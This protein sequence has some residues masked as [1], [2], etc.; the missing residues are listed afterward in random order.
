M[1]DIRKLIDILN[2]TTV[3][4]AIATGPAAPIGEVHKRVEEEQ[5]NETGLPEVIEY[6]NWENSALVTEKKT[7]SMR[8]RSKRVVK[9][10]YGVDNTSAEGGEASESQESE[11][12]KGIKESLDTVAENTGA[13][14]YAPKSQGGTRKE[15]LAKFKKTRNP[16][17]AEAARRAGATQRELQDVREDQVN[18]EDL[19]VNPAAIKKAM[20]IIAKDKVRTDHEVE[21]ARSDLFQAAK[22]AQQIHAMIKDRSE[23]DGL[24]GWVQEKIVK[25]ADYLNTVREYLEG[26]RVEQGVAEG[27]NINE[28]YIKSTKD[29]VNVLANLRQIAKH[30]EIGSPY[31]GNLANQ[32]ANDVWDVYSWLEN[33]ADV[34]NPQLKAILN[35]VFELRK[36]AKALE[37]GGNSGQNRQFANQIV[38]TLYPLMQWIQ[39]NVSDQQSVAEGKCPECGGPAFSEEAIA[40]AKDACYH[41]VKSRYKVWPSAYASGALSKCRKVGASNWGNKSK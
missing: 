19:I 10:V 20:G 38:N 7:K 41:K 14:D 13:T 30:I 24:E 40:E 5:T 21:M 11:K 39:M 22:N 34:Y 36:Q 31:N 6:G 35:N 1:S 16:K 9:S 28:A 29:A 8:P 2:E 15:L 27:Q 17:D 23:D 32:Y 4:G 18:E 12:K 33:R 26:Q 37:T 25:A 3:A